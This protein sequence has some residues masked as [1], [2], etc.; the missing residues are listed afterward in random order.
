VDRR[1]LPR[2]IQTV[3]TPWGRIRI[4]KIT[5]PGQSHGPV[6]DFSIEYDDLR[7]LARA[8]KGTLKEL[9]TKIR[10]WFLNRQPTLL[11][12]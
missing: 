5:R 10:N 7:E 4:K 6:D 11:G 9:D 3:Q 8:Q 12:A 2:T 1:S